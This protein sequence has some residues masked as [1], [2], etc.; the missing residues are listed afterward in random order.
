VNITRM[1]NQTVELKTLTGGGTYGDHFAAPVTK[2]AFV[3]DGRKLV[4]DS[5][6]TEV[7]SETTLYGPI[8]DVD[9]YKP[10]SEV[11]VNGR[12]AFVITAM[13][14]DSAGPATIHHTQVQ[15]T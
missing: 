2:K 6:G 5:T 11:T 4:R 1:F 15:L 9:D 7:V 8:G 10:G 12:T 13:R 3:N 14:R